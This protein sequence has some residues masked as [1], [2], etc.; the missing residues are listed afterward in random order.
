[1]HGK[2]KSENGNT[3]QGVICIQEKKSD[4]ILRGVCLCF[5]L[6]VSLQIRPE[7]HEGGWL[8]DSEIPSDRKCKEGWRTHQ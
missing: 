6:T 1:M 3:K 5:Y 7:L 4:E 2:Q 8:G